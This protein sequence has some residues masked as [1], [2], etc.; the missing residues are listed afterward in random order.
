MSLP[1]VSS[2]ELEGLIAGETVVASWVD[3]ALRASP[4]LLQRAEALV[5]EGAVVATSLEWGA[6][7]ADLTHGVRALLTLFKAVDKV[8]SLEVPLG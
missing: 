3:G 6:L 7:P 5:E 2:F 1:P 4:V 8:T